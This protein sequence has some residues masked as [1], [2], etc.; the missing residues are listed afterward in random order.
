MKENV[1]LKKKLDLSIDVIEDRSAPLALPTERD[2]PAL[3]GCCCCT[4][5]CCESCG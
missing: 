4:C 2:L 1:E 5:T 3:I